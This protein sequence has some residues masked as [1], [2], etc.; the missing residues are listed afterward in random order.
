MGSAPPGLL[1]PV[2]L[3]KGSLISR[4]FFFYLGRQSLNPSLTFLFSHVA[5]Q[6]LISLVGGGDG[7]KEQFSNA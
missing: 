5:S 1:Y 6:R 3:S 2:A 4:F 7:V